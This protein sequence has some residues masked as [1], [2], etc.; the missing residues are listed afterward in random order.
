MLLIALKKHVHLQEHL[1]IS[2]LITLPNIFETRETP[3]D[4]ETIDRIMAAIEQLT[5]L[6]QEMRITEG[7]ALAVDLE[8]RIEA[9]KGYLE[10]L[11]PRANIVMEQKKSSSLLHLKLH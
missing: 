2:D 6:V 8:S 3:L 7:K 9:I 5:T 1:T 10:Q 4:Q 11:E